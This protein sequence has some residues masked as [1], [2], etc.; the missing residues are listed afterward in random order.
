MKFEDYI[1]EYKK[2]LPNSELDESRSSKMKQELFEKSLKIDYKKVRFSKLRLLKYT[3]PKLVRNIK[4]FSVAA[5]FF[6]AVSGTYLIFKTSPEKQIKV[7]N[8]IVNNKD[9][10]IPT[11]VIDNEFII[12]E[13]LVAIDLAINSRS[14]SEIS[15][16]DILNLC[17]SSIKHITNDYKLGIKEISKQEIRIEDFLSND[18]LI[19]I[20]LKVDV[21]KLKIYPSI[22]KRSKNNTDTINYQSLNYYDIIKDIEL[23]I[24][25][26]L[27]LME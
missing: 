18:T 5:S 19:T 2:K 4:Y 21:R 23:E 27:K 8:N 12:N 24:Q 15:N 26:K 3:N 10:I 16:E 11:E 22:S 9:S 14:D 7:N 6:V 1:N 13:K 20:D 17:R 25:G